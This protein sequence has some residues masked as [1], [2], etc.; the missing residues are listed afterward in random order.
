MD[1][2]FASVEQLDFPELR[3][4]PVIVGGTSS[5]GVAA[6]CSYEA[7]KFGVHSAMPI[8]QAKK[9]CPNGIYVHGRHERYE[10]ISREIFSLLSEIT[11]DIVKV[12]I[13][14]AYLDVTNLYLSAEYIGKYIKKKIKKET[15]LTVSVGISYNMFLAKLA[16]DWDKPDGFFVIKKE[17]VPDILKPLSILKIH[18]LGKKSAEKLNNIGIYTIEELLEYD[19]DVLTNLL[20]SMGEEIY[21]KIRGID[22]RKVASHTERK[23]IGTEITFAED[24]DV[25]DEISARAYK[26]LHEV[27]DMLLK[28]KMLAKTIVLKIKFEDFTQVTRSKSLEVYTDDEKNF[29]PLLKELLGKVE[30]KG[31]IRLLGITLANLISNR[32]KQLEIFDI[33]GE[34]D[35][36]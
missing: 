17:D 6:T 32:E 8:F 28:K 13:D 1:A 14:E 7:R 25:F 27:N 5:R 24:T 30:Y 21:N 23:S 31:K 33:I 16:S 4:K 12:S 3:G 26:Y 2:F 34:E 20:G 10:K 29:K 18:G 15:G 35:G 9:L 36:K 22:L 19:K 11:D